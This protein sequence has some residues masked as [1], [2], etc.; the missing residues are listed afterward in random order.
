MKI[1]IIPPITRTGESRYSDCLIEGLKKKGINIEIINS[2]FPFNRPNIKIFLGSFLLKKMMKEKKIDILHNTDNLGPFLINDKEIKTISTVFDIAPVMLPEIHDPIM[3]FNFKTVLPRLIRNSDCIISSSCS[4]KKDLIEKFGISKNKIRVIHLGIDKSFFYPRVGDNKVLKSYG[5]KNEFLMYSGGD[6]P[7]KNL[8]NLI[9]AFGEIYQEI[10]HDLVLVGP[11]R[12]EN[13]LKIISENFNGNKKNL[14][15]RILFTGYVN[16]ED[17]PHIYSAAS[18]F[19][20]PSLYEGFGFPP[21]EAMACG[22][23]V[24]V[25]KNSSLEEI[26]GRAGLFINDPLN[27]IEIS[28]KILKLVNEGELKNKLKSKGII[29]ADK[30]NWN[31]TVKETLTVYN[32]II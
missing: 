19:I 3:K 29:Q 15:K 25:S 17:L 14:I 8:K 26:V 12:K 11:I 21:L 30:F 7:R 4:T 2:K 32:K 20:F 27:H 9:L 5:I 18:A 6:N 10:S 13:I 31:N 16:S 22:T 23:P 28:E 1:A 24:I